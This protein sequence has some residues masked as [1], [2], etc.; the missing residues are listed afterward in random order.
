MIRMTLDL[1]TTSGARTQRPNVSKCVLSAPNRLQ[2]TPET[3]LVNLGAALNIIY[4]FGCLKG[5]MVV[6]T[7]LSGFWLIRYFYPDMMG[8]D[9]GPGFENME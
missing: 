1:W 5:T 2:Y 3:Y 9:M 6:Y 7:F 8:Y 4:L